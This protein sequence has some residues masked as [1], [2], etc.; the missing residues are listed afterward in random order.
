MRVVTENVHL[1]GV[2][3]QLK[4]YL[5]CYNL[6]FV[7]IPKDYKVIFNKVLQRIKIPSNSKYNN[8]FFSLSV[9]L[10]ES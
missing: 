10:N 9:V 2:N 3:S 4:M 5:I 8:M 6:S 7:K 1:A